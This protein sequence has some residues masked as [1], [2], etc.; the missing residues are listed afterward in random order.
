MFSSFVFILSCIKNSRV[1]GTLKTNV[2]LIKQQDMTDGARV[3]I[4]TTLGVQWDMGRRFS[5]S[6][7]LNARSNQLKIRFT[8][9]LCGLWEIY[10][11]QNQ[12]LE[13]AVGR[14]GLETRPV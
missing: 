13:E 6:I 14:W 1:K 10:C 2:N 12:V 3:P 4:N 11:K 9:G 5:P 7:V 8:E